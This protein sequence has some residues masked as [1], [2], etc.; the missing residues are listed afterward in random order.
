[1]LMCKDSVSILKGG[2]CYVLLRG[3]NRLGTASTCWCHLLSLHPCFWPHWWINQLCLYPESAL[4]FS[5]SEP[6][7][8]G[9]LVVLCAS[10]RF[11]K[12]DGGSLWL[13]DQTSAFLLLRALQVT[14]SRF[15][16]RREHFQNRRAKAPWKGVPLS[17]HSASPQAVNSP[18]S[19]HFLP[20]PS[21]CLRGPLPARS[22][23]LPILPFSET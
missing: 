23:G 21:R 5:T 4:P 22:L 12:P 9:L 3:F 7:D 14:P 13:V 17:S 16:W 2:G 18:S 6:S 19:F 11:R 20:R 8:R 10:C 15:N 1:M